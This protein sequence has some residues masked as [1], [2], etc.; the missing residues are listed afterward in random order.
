MAQQHPWLVEEAACEYV[1]VMSI[2]ARLYELNSKI[3]YIYINKF[4]HV[5]VHIY[6]IYTRFNN[7]CLRVR[8][9]V[10]GI[11]RPIVARSV[12]RRTATKQTYIFC[13]ERDG[14][15]CRERER[16]RERERQRGRQRGR[17]RWRQ[18]S[19]IRDIGR[20]TQRA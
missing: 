18:H 14:D 5:H 12:L 13:R 17:H 15:S 16:E 10:V 3:I 19:D 6:Y 4:N 7:A 20:D 11:D 9:N 2:V 8:A 1:C